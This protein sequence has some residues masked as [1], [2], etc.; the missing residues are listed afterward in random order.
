M[1][2]SCDMSEADIYRFLMEMDYA[3]KK[4][5]VKYEW[6]LVVDALNAF[7]FKVVSIDD[8]TDHDIL[9]MLERMQEGLVNSIHDQRSGL[10]KVAC[11]VLVLIAQFRTP[12]FVEAENAAVFTTW[13]RCLLRKCANRDKIRTLPAHNACR[14]IIACI[15]SFY[16]NNKDNKKQFLLSKLADIFITFSSL[17]TPEEIDPLWMKQVKS[18]TQFIKNISLMIQHIAVLHQTPEGDE[19]GE[20]E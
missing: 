15:L 2:A 5:P 11:Q 14:D 10:I 17:W 3:D 1:G 13:M 18:V 12:L 8:Y 16:V 4:N 7:Q 6:K 19:K 9:A 20:D